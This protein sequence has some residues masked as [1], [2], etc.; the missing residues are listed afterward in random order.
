MLIREMLAASGL[1]AL[2]SEVLLAHV[3]Q[4]PRSWL[5]AH[6][7]QPLT[8]SDVKR[9]EELAARR[10]KCEPIAYIIGEKEFFG[11][12]FQVTPDVLI[13]RPATEEFVICALDFIRSPRLIEREIDTGISALCVPVA[14]GIPE[15]LVDIGT[16][17]GCIAATLALEGRSEKIIAVDSSEAALDVAKQNFANFKLS[18]ISA[19]GD[20]PS[21]VRSILQPFFVLSNPPYIP[22]GTKLQ[23][24]VSDHEPHEAL[25]AGKEG[26]D[27]L[28]GLA[29][30]A[31][32]NPACLGI[33][34]ELKTGQIIA[35]K[36]LL[37][38][39]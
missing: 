32:G 11:R 30:A 26:M 6:A 15:L 2:D 22:E 28:A 16:G 24:N 27:V 18:I 14:S 21:F 13:P 39:M 10:R 9:F 1:P 20:G 19:V 35:V 23:K 5:A 12:I 8:G 31:V 25:F 7:D 17:S 33:A 3:L 37:G 36:N 29:R 34:L 38:V 4:K